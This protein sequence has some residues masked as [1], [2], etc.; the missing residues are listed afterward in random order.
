MLKAQVPVI[1]HYHEYFDGNG[2]PDRRKGK[3]ICIE[4]RIVVIA[5]AVEAMYSDRPHGKALDSQGVINEI[6]NHAGTKFDPQV[7]EAAVILAKTRFEPAILL[8]RAPWSQAMRYFAHAFE[9]SG[10]LPPKPG[11]LR[12]RLP[13]DMADNPSPQRAG[14]E[15]P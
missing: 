15:R 9:I 2:Y 3:Q 5:D 10:N 4:A 13:D 8:W 12:V 1:R 11:C 14:V 7:L 6:K